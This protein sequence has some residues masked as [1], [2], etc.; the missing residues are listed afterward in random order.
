MAEEG[1]RE[2]LGHGQIAAFELE[3]E[4]AAEDNREMKVLGL[5][6]HGPWFQGPRRA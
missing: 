4:G 3:E 5:G 1:P 6:R 2:D